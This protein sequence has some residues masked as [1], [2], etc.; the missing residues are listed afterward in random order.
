MGSHNCC[1]K[2]AVAVKSKSGMKAVTPKR[3]VRLSQAPKTLEKPMEVSQEKQISHP[4]I[5][6]GLQ[7]MSITDR[8][9]K[10]KMNKDRYEAQQASKGAKSN[11]SDPDGSLTTPEHKEDSSKQLKAENEMKEMISSNDRLL[12]G[13]LQSP[14]FLTH[15]YRKHRENDG[16][17]TGRNQRI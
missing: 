5:E 4:T 8:I 9:K 6:S 14:H 7:S 17:A 13:K 12:R 2:N 3:S 15:L 10:I 16:R 11:Q 1:A